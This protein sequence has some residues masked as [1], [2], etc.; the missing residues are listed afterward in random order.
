MQI[1]L[2]WGEKSLPNKLMIISRKERKF[3]SYKSFIKSILMIALMSFEFLFKLKK[4]DS[5][6]IF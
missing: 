5:Q 6:K 3:Y 2:K 1:V 4:I